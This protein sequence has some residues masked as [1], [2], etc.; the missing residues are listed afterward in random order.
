MSKN[1]LQKGF[2]GLLNT[3]QSQIEDDD[4]TEISYKINKKKG[5]VSISGKKNNEAFRATQQIYGNNGTL[6]SASRFNANIDRSERAKIV[7]DMYRKG[8]KQQ[9]IADT[10]GISQSQVSN[11][12]N[13]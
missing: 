11:I 10:L 3:I 9:E 7:R 8:Y 4:V 5:I 13:S 1:E 6:Q 12:L 2:N